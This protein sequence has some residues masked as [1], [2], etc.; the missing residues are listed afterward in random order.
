M[1]RLLLALLMVLGFYTSTYS[2]DIVREGNTFSSVRTSSKAQPTKTK[3]AWKDS[4][5]TEYPIYMGASGSCYVIKV[6]Q[7]TGKEYKNYMKPEVSEQIC[8]EMGVKYTSKSRGTNK[9][10][11]K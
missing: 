1:R 9:S 2:Q 6:S 5:G 11:V 8:K 3:F 10:M 7:K 4:K